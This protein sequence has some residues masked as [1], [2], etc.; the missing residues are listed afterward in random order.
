MNGRVHEP[1][2]LSFYPAHE[3]TEIIINVSLSIH[4][5]IGN[6]HSQLSTR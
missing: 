4:V 1:W 6:H 2:A 3:P 5:V